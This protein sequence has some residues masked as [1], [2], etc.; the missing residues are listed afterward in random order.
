MESLD[1]LLFGWWCFTPRKD[2]SEGPSN[3][4]T[5]L[6]K[7]SALE[8][9]KERIERICSA[10]SV[11][12]LAVIMLLTLSIVT[13]AAVQGYTEPLSMKR[14][15]MRLWVRICRF[16]WRANVNES[17][18]INIIKEYAEIRRNS[19]SNQCSTTRLK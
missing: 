4:A 17:E 2:W 7:N 16:K 15:W 11:N 3:Y 13:L 14:Q 1:R 12:R 8:G 5:Y 19:T 10:E 9:C 6:W 18:I